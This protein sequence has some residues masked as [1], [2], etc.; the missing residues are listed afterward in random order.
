MWTAPRLPI[1]KVLSLGPLSTAALD[2]LKFYDWYSSRM[3]GVLLSGRLSQ[4]SE[5]PF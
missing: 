5:C 2:L 3:P 1:K 4:T